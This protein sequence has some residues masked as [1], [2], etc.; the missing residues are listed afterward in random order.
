MKRY[1]LKDMTFFLCLMAAAMLGHSG[2]GSLETPPMPTENSKADQMN[3]D[4]FPVCESDS[5]PSCD[6]NGS[7][8][9]DDDCSVDER[10]CGAR[11][12]DLR[13]D[14]DNCG[15]CGVS[16]SKMEN[17]ICD[18]AICIQQPCDA[19]NCNGCC[20]A[21]GYCDEGTSDKA[22]GKDGQRCGTCNGISL[23]FENQCV[24]YQGGGRCDWIPVQE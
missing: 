2:C 18:N 8:N 17:Q 6:P 13:S 15:A 16:C 14:F 23:N 7:C 22:C 11:C 3:V 1:N 10:C 24:E 21:L 12:V 19:S 5:D 4:P 9:S 20:D